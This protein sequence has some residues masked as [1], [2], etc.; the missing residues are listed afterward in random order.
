MPVSIV[1]MVVVMAVVPVPVIVTVI[2]VPVI[3]TVPVVDSPYDS[4]VARGLHPCR[5]SGNRSIIAR[6]PSHK[7]D[8]HQHDPHQFPPRSRLRRTPSVREVQFSRLVG[9]CDH[10]FSPVNRLATVRSTLPE[11]AG[12]PTSTPSA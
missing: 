4:A 11:P 10:D 7:D 8:Q 5:R 3:S 12:G 2:A 9:N 1:A 6:E